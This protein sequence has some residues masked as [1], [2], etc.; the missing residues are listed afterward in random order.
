MKGWISL[1]GIREHADRTLA[2][3]MLGLNDALAEAEGRTVLDLGAAECAISKE[4]AKA[5]ATRVFAI[6]SLHEHLEVARRYCADTPQVEMQQGYLQDWIP[7]H[8]PPEVFDIVLCLGIAHKIHDPSIVLRFACRSA[9][10]LVLFRA[11][12]HAWN[13]NVT[14]K[15]G[16]TGVTRQTVH[17]PT[18][19]A[20]EGFA[21]ERHI[22]GARG[23]G[24]E[25]WRRK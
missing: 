20:D 16:R 4:F 8:D 14:A 10:D 19:M 3:Q 17:V 13:G 2:E 24:V 9:R 5:G 21:L 1:P 6:E 23:E 18:V 22:P 15:H 25:Y 12:A 7:A 11:P